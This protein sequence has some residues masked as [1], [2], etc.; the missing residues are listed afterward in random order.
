MQLRKLQ[1]K[2]V[3]DVSEMYYWKREP[4]DWEKHLQEYGKST[5]FTNDLI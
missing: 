2:L 5:I 1:C 4:H 3:K